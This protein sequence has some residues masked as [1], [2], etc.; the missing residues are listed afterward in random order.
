LVQDVAALESSHEYISILRAK[1]LNIKVKPKTVRYGSAILVDNVIT[2][3]KNVKESFLNYLDIDFRKTFDLSKF[4]D[5][6]KLIR[7][8]RFEAS[9][10]LVGLKYQSFTASISSDAVIMAKQYDSSI[11]EWKRGIFER[12]KQE[13]FYHD[14]QSLES[15]K[16]I[17]ENYNEEQR[18][19]IF[20]PVIDLFQDVN[21]FEFS[22]TNPS[23]SRIEKAFRPVSK[24][25][26]DVLIPIVKLEEKTK[27]YELFQT[28]G[29]AKPDTGG[30]IPKSGVISSQIL[31]S[32]EFTY[33]VQDIK[34]DKE[35]L[36]LKDEILISIKYAKPVFSLE[37][38]PL[39]LVIHAYDYQ[40]LIKDFNRTFF[41]TYNRIMMQKSNEMTADEVEMK[42]FLDSVVF[43]KSL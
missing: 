19:R 18:R 1:A 33:S 23:F 17:S 13:V 42:S 32:A 22:I 21:P 16:A 39:K 29:L 35:Y 36:A 12:Y 4:S 8:L 15:S 3:L 20:R 26:R 7:D 34:V 43:A 37:F 30:S 11:F 5:P 24:P 31:E 28:I 9:P 14:Y 38:T 40:E 6:E 10:L 41:G 27:D 2:V 25:I